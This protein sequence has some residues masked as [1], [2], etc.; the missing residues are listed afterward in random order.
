MKFGSYAILDNRRHVLKDEDK[1][2][3]DIKSPT[4]KDEGKLATFYS[5]NESPMLVDVAALEVA[6]SFGE[7]NIPGD[8]G[9]PILSP[10]DSYDDVLA[11]VESMPTALM[12]ELWEAVGQAIPFWGP[13]K[14]GDTDPK[15][16]GDQ[17]V[18]D[19]L[20]TDGPLD[21]VEEAQEKS[22]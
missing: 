5:Q 2:W 12:Y 4:V 13:L 19:S 22:S 20:E 16:D 6:L 21:A 9:K 11:V 10:D 7:T 18:Q 8:N 14:P 17:D 1:W 3:W 15:A